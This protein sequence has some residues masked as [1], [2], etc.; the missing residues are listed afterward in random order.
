MA[1]VVPSL[2]LLLQVF[3][4]IL[5]SVFAYDAFKIYRT[6]I[7]PRATQGEWLCSGERRGPLY[8][9]PQ[10]P[11]P[12]MPFPAWLHLHSG[13]AVTL[14]L[15]GFRAQPDKGDDEAQTHLWICW[16]PSLLPPTPGLQR[17]SLV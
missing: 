3:G 16:H 13:P 15:P 5:V 14:G 12:D 8:P 1:F 7:V 2:P 10:L 11:Y 9:L 4:I 6:E 17:W